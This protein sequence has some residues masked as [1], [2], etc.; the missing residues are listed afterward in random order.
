MNIRFIGIDIAKHVFH[1]IG[2]DPNGKQLLKKKRHRT[3]ML[4]YFFNWSNLLLTQ[5]EST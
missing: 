5:G 2:L 3:Q 4:N 1:V